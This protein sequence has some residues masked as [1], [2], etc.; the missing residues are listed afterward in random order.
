MPTRT[1]SMVGTAAKAM[2]KSWVSFISFDD[3]SHQRR[4]AHS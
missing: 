2:I 3:I 1:V 4:A